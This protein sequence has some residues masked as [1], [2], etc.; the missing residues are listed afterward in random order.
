M[1]S[2]AYPNN[3]EQKEIADCLSVLDEVITAQSQKVE[4][5]KAHKKGLL[6]QLFPAEGEAVPSRRFPEFHDAGEWD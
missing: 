6:Q 2:C 5:L 3:D 4:T 1:A